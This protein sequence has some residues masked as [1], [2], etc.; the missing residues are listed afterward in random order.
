MADDRTNGSPAAKQ[1][2]PFFGA[3]RELAVFLAIFL[4]AKAVVAEPY[5]VPSGSMQPTLLIGDELLAAKYSYGYSRYSLPFGVG[6]ASTTRLFGALPARGDVVVF[7]LPRN[8]AQVY[9]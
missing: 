7:H 1:S 5:Y 4:L 9:V 3:V 8:P 2:H 6:P